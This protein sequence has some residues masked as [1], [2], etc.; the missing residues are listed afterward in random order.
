MCLQGII[1]LCKWITLFFLPVLHLMIK[2]YITSS[3]VIFLKVVICHSCI[4]DSLTRSFEM[5]CLGWVTDEV[6]QYM[7]APV[8]DVP[9]GSKIFSNS[10]TNPL[11]FMQ[12]IDTTD[13]IGAGGSPSESDQRVSCRELQP[14]VWCRWSVGIPRLFS[15]V[16]ICLILFSS[17]RSMIWN[18]N[19]LTPY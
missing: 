4:F 11:G 17:H 6:K 12:Q 3:W 16:L 5:I 8:C 9:D 7:T 19:D 1:K 15:A 14:W 2:L 13:C 10:V 18:N